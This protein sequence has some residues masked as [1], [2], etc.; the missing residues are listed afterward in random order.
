[1]SSQQESSQ[2]D[3]RSFAH[4]HGFSDLGLS[5]FWMVGAFFLFQ[6]AG[7]VAAITLLMLFGDPSTLLE[8]D[9]T[10]AL[11]DQANFLFAGNS[12][13]QIAFLGVA[14]LAVTRWH[15]TADDDRSRYLRLHQS[16]GIL[17]GSALA[18][19]AFIVIQPIVWASGWLNGLIP[20]PESFEALQASQLE[21]IQ[22]YISQEGVLGLALFHI[23]VVPAIC[24]EVL[25]RGY[26]LRSFERSTSTWVA[27]LLSGALF[28]LYH[29]QLTNMLP[30]ALL[31]VA[32][33]AI[34]VATGSIIPAM[35]A[36]FINNAGAVL[37]VRFAPDS[38]MVQMG[39][40]TPPPLLY[41][42]VSV[43]GALILGRMFLNHYKRAQT[44]AI[45]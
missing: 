8:G 26:L 29:L 10:A 40:E 37:L 23:A 28:G 13:G 25:F 3:G 15:L 2:P 21:M 6:I 39:T 44:H 42:V 14:T 35:V 27:I 43:I 22:S 18:A 30:L 36:H 19:L 20:V 4:R 38:P 41:I 11:Q 9:P 5:L 12:I 17:K 32:L 31:G 33:G 45:I 7:L 24:E 16:Q 34:T 1:M